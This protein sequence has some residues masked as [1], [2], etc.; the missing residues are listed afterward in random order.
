LNDIHYCL[1][2]WGTDYEKIKQ[3]CLLAEELGYYLLCFPYHANVDK[4]LA[5]Y[6]ELME[7][8][9][10]DGFVLSNIEYNDPR[11]NLLLERNFPFVAFGRSNPDLAE[12]FIFIAGEDEGTPFDKLADS[13]AWLVL[14]RPVEIDR[15]AGEV[16]RVA[17]RV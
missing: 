17:E 8:R 3:T 7:T 15:L 14:H 4:H 11:V 13:A 1:E 9:R 2:I 6:S 16:I 10:V 5:T 12:R